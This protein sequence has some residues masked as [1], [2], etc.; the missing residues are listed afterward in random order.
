MRLICFTAYDTAAME[1]IRLAAPT[2]ENQFARL[3]V[4]EI[5]SIVG[6]TD[7][8][9]EQYSTY[10]A[11]DILT[12]EGLHIT[13]T[14]TLSMNDGHIQSDDL[15]YFHEVVSTYQFGAFCWFENEILVVL[16]FAR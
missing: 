13:A 8:V 11:G 1:E 14:E 9:V 7:L 15:D 3:V 10:F 4:E 16:C 5:H 2:A 6:Q 12:D